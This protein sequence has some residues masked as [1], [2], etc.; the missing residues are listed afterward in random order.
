MPTSLLHIFSLV[1]EWFLVIVFLSVLVMLFLWMWSAIRSKVPFV[2]VPTNVL[3]DICKALYIQ[4][5]SVVYDLGSGDGKVLFYLSEQVPKARYI[6]IE[7]SLFPN[8]LAHIRVWFSGAKSKN[9][10]FINKDFHAANLSD[11][12]HVF[13][14]L[15][16]IAMDEL[17]S[18]L[19]RELKPGTRLVS[20]SYQFTLRRP[21]I[22]IDLERNTYSLARKLYVYEF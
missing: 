1:S 15:Y 22:E 20:A 13:T 7:N 17:L 19:E 12:T 6:G 5:G 21:N 8:I 4:D 16:P 9:I 10:K 2:P 3:R 18:K 11:A 14:Y